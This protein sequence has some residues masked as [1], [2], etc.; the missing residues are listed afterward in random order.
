VIANKRFIVAM[1]KCL[2]LLFQS[3]PLALLV[4]SSLVSLIF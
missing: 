4:L 2:A 1:L 3:L